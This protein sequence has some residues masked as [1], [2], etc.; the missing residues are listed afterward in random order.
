VRPSGTDRVSGATTRGLCPVLPVGWH[1]TASIGVRGGRIRPEVAAG[2]FSGVRA[3]GAPRGRHGRDDRWTTEQIV[4]PG[5]NPLLTIIQC[6][7]PW[8]SSQV[9]SPGKIEHIDW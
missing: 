6:L 1:T 3:A 4:N 7:D 2:A 8:V 5:R 9:T